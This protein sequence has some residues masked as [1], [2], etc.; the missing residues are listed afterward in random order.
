[1][2]LS[3][4]ISQRGAVSIY[5]MGRFPVTLYPEALQELGKA[6]PAILKFVGEN[7]AKFAEQ[8]D[9]FAAAEAIA[10]TRKLDGKAREEFV[11]KLLGT[12]KV[13]KAATAKSDLVE[14]LLAEAKS[15]GL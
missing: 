4:K 6:M 8:A 12:E 14:K 15:R 11:A 2:N 9:R 3:W 10:D 7:K 13:S 1:M 5:G